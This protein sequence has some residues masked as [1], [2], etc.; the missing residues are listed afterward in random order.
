MKKSILSADKDYSFRDF[1]DM[2]YPTE[3]IVKEFGYDFSFEILELPRDIIDEEAIK[4]FQE[5]L[6][7]KMPKI[8]L[9]T[10]MSR[11]EFLIA[12]ILMKLMNF[13]DVRITSEYPIEA[14]KN[15]KGTLDYLVR[16][17]K[18]LT[19][20]E[21]KKGDLDRGFTQ[22]TVELIA[23][24]K[25]EEENYNILFGVVTTGDLWKFGKLD[26]TQKKI[27]KDINTYRI[28]ADMSDIF[29]IFVGILK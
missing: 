11:R 16:S 17:E 25:Y 2:A 1:F 7:R 3:D 29:S 14:E 28:P 20:I 12:P 15:L 6:I 13:I 19:I 18:K 24:G 23:M 5:E 10:E 21:A 22:L 4:K 9:N 27:S 26:N 8:S